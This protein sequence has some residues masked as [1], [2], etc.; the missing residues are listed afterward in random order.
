[1]PK[2]VAIPDEDLK[3]LEAIY[4][5]LIP[6]TSRSKGSLTRIINN[7]RKHFPEDKRTRRLL[8]RLEARIEN[9]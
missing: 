2:R 3:V 1:V 8:T 4:H 7:Y 5:N 6:Y 9:P